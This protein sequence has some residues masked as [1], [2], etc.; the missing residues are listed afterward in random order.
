MSTFHRLS[1]SSLQSSPSLSWEYYYMVKA[2]LMFTATDRKAVHSIF[3][4]IGGTEFV[5]HK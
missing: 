2:G 1:L 3:T 4:N 5:Y